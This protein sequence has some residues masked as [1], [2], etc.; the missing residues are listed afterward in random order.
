MQIDG[1]RYWNAVLCMAQCIGECGDYVTALDA[2]TGDGDHWVNLNMGYAALLERA[3]EICA[4]A[5][6]EQFQAIARVFMTAI[7]GSSGILY[8]SA[9]LS[10]AKQIAGKS[11]IMVRELVEVLDAMADGI[12]RRGRSQPGDKTM[13]DAIVP[14]AE[15]MRRAAVVGAA[16]ERELLLAMKQGAAAGAEQTRNM[17]A[18][19][20]RAFYQADKGVGHLDPGAVTMSYQLAALADSLLSELENG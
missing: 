5:L 1:T 18:V 2:A 8:A 3:E 11:A 9:Y 20:G 15:A 16:R 4:L 13:V 17:P 6:P 12:M 7:G 14:A 10:A 19:R